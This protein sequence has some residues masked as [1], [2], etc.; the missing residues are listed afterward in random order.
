MKKDD[1]ELFVEEG[2]TYVFGDGKNEYVGSVIKISDSAVII[3]KNDGKKRLLSFENIQTIDEDMC[4]DDMEN[5]SLE[6]VVKN[7]RINMINTSNNVLDISDYSE[8]DEDISLPPF[9]L[10]LIDSVSFV[11]FIKFNVIDKNLIKEDNFIGTYEDVKKTNKNLKNYLEKGYSKD[12]SGKVYL[13]MAKVAYNASKFNKIPAK[14]IRELIEAALVEMADK[15]VINA[16]TIDS[17]RS[18]YMEALK[19]SKD[20]ENRK[21]A[22]N[23]LVYSY[24]VN[25]EELKNEIVNG[26]N[27]ISKEYNLDK[28]YQNTLIYS[29]NIREF[30]I[31]SFMIY[32]YV[33]TVVDM[34]I[35]SIKS[36]RS[37]YEICKG[38]LAKIQGVKEEELDSDFKDAWLGS[39]N[40]YNDQM[41]SLKETIGLCI[42]EI[43]MDDNLK[44]RIQKIQEIRDK[45]LL[46]GLDDDNVGDFYKTID[47]LIGTK[48][49][50]TVNEKI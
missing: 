21:K 38:E 15:K 28:Y 8:N 42:T 16:E 2:K 20:G 26:N 24:F 31:S 45:D 50:Y 7:N 22:T 4:I 41:N 17:A 19:I 40:E 23:L 48:N 29:N 13:A 11:D 27:D 5:V 34:M 9:L 30:I 6:T 1:I 49:D 36:Y 35:E 39:Y 32:P 12:I 37:L 33:P 3:Q 25:N 10:S 14:Y 44:Q 18:F 47:G 43:E 46:F